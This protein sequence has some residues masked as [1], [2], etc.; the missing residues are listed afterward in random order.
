[1]RMPRLL[2]LVMAA[3]CAGAPAFAED[4]AVLGRVLVD[5]TGLPLPAAGVTLTGGGTATSDADGRYVVFGPSGART[6]VVQAPGFTS[7][8][9]PVAVSAGGAVLALDARLTSLAAPVAVDQTGGELRA[10]TLAV[11]V[12]A[13]A[14]NASTEFRLTALSGQGLPARL[15][16]GWSPVRAFDLRAGASLSESLSAQATD[17]PAGTLHLVRHRAD[18]QAWVMVLSGL[19][20]TDGQLAVDLAEPGAYALVAADATPA[21][22]V[23]G[24]GGALVGVPAVAPA[25]GLIGSVRVEPALVSATGGIGRAFVHLESP[26]ALPS[27]T[28]FQ[29]RLEDDYL[30]DGDPVFEEPRVQDLVL[31]RAQPGS[32]SVLE[33]VLPVRAVQTF[34]AERLVSGWVHVALWTRPADG[35]GVLGGADAATLESGA[36]R[37]DVAAGSLPANTVLN[38]QAVS[39]SPF[40]P[41]SPAATPLGEVVLDLSAP[42]WARPRSCHWPRPA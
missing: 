14:V 4:G 33:A 28:V 26:T 32:G 41:T 21:P 31:Y 3:L 24:P 6:I 2:T 15:P 23:P 7:V 11:T 36:F 5:S 35:G 19:T 20:P 34:S 8:A 9:R 22:P 40:V 1:M 38:L 12:P 39:L 30:I 42:C 27:G 13:G 10:G 16:L 18:D 17:L 25:G 29:A 37:L